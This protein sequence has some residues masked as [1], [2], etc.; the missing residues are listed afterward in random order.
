[1]WKVVDMR[2]ESGLERVWRGVA[3]GGLRWED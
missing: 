3:G 2:S 1:M